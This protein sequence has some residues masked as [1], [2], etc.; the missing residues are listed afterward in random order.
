MGQVRYP[1][2]SLVVGGLICHTDGNVF[3]DFPFFSTSFLW[4]VGIVSS[5]YLLVSNFLF[6]F[7]L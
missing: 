2:F 3:M 1:S 6:S 4:L 5:L 7:V